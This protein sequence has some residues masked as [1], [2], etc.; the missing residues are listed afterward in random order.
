[1]QNF[2]QFGLWINLYVS[3]AKEEIG[4]YYYILRELENPF[5]FEGIYRPFYIT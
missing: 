2:N 3:I 4:T 1:M 5:V